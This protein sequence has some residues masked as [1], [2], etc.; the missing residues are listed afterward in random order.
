MSNVRSVMR[1]HGGKNKLARRIIPYFPPHRVYVEPFGGAANVL[2][3]K[4]RTY[5]EVYN[6]LDPEVV[7]V[8]RV[9]RDDKLS[10]RLRAAC[11]LTPFSR[12]EFFGSYESSTDSVEQARRTIFRS[13]AGFGSASASKGRT[14]FRACS[15]RSGTTPA[16]DWVNLADCIPAWTERLMGVVIENRDALLCMAQHD[17]SKTLFYVDPPYPLSTRWAEAHHK[18]AA[19]RHEMTDEDHAR[20]LAF[21]QDVEGYVVLSGYACPLYDD[22]LKGWRRVE[23][24]TFAD[25]AKP[26]TEVLW[27]N[28]SA[29]TELDIIAGQSSLFGEAA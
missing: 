21:L 18:G 4:E 17:S 19:Y 3:Q 20:L 5:A 9:L 29:T 24:S 8:F 13:C 10:P 2:M 23:M 11:A 7:N 1:Y 15:N 12:D 16:R 25:G 28:P 22:A 14:G 26:R 6:E 27:M